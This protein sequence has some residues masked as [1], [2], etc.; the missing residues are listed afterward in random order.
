MALAV[1][2]DIFT[3][4]LGKAK[5][6]FSTHT[7]KVLLTNTVPNYTT[8]VSKA[9]I[10]QI[11]A[12]TGYTTDGATLTTTT[13]AQTGG[14]FKWVVSD[15]TFTATGSMGPFQYIVIYNSTNNRLI[16]YYDYGSAI[17]LASGETFTCDFDQ[18]NG[19]IRVV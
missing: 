7:F 6:D 13:A 5:H 19:L 4:D 18:T 12:G 15:L 8:G 2:F 14:T 11:S 16:Q 9:D 3:E 10:T 1:Q 17:T